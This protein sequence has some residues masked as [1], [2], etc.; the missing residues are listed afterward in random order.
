MASRASGS[1]LPW[2]DASTIAR[3]GCTKANSS[4]ATIQAAK[5]RPWSRRCRAPG[6]AHGQAGGPKATRRLMRRLLQRMGP[7]SVLVIVARGRRLGGQRAYGCLHLYGFT[8]AVL[9]FDDEGQ[10]HG[11]AFLHLLLEV[12]QHQIGRAHV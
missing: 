9:A 11:L 7:V 8:L 3:A 5:R 12:Q 6:N 2:P 1:P 10:R 4:A